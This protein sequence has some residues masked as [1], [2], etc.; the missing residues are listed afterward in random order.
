MQAVRKMGS[1][2]KIFGMLPGMGQ[3]RDQLES[4]DEKDVDHIEA[5]IFSMTPQERADVSI[6]NG[7]RRARIAQ[8]AGVTVTEVNNLVNRFTEAKKMMSQFGAM[9]GMPGVPGMPG[10]GKGQ[11]RQPKKKK[12]NAKGVSGNPAKRAAGARAQQQPSDPMAAF[13]MKQNLND[14]DLSSVDLPAD[15]KKMLKNQG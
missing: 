12:K 11:A 3:M 7:S 8:G 15:L 9:S 13:G 2:S 6:L 1:L 5:I 4:V 14:F 10:R